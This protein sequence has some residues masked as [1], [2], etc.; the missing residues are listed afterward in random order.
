MLAPRKSS[1]VDDGG[2]FKLSENLKKNKNFPSRLK[3]LR[4]GIQLHPAYSFL[5]KQNKFFIFYFSTEW[6][7]NNH[8]HTS[9]NSFKTKA[10]V[11][12]ARRDTPRIEQTVF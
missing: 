3:K 9:S 2:G 6:C 5:S 1:G 12:I 7:N 8:S 4:R 10:E 11:E